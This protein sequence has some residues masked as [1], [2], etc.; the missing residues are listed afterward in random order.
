[1]FISEN[2]SNVLAAEESSY[3]DT[4]TGVTTEIFCL[5]I[6]ALVCWILIFVVEYIYGKKSTVSK[7]KSSS[8]TQESQQLIEEDVRMEQHRVN[9][10]SKE[11]IQK[12]GL[13]LQNV[14]KNYGDLKAVDNLSIGI[15]S[16]EC[17][18]LLGI[19]GAGKTTTFK[20]MT[21]DESIGSGDIWV[22]GINLKTDLKKAQQI[23]GYC[24]Q[25][26]ALMDNLTGWETLRMYC[27]L[28]GITGTD[29]KAISMGFAEDLDLKPHMNKL[30]KNYSG[31]NKRKLSTAIALLSR[32]NVIY[33]DE[34]TT[35]MD[36]ATRHKFWQVV[37]AARDSGKCVVLTSHSMEECEAL[38]TRLAIM[39]NGQFQ[40][41]GS[42]QHLK[43]KFTNGFTLVVK[44]K[45]Y[46]DDKMRLLD[47]VNNVK[48]FI[49]DTFQNST[50][51]EEH[52]ELL[53][54]HVHDRVMNWSYLFGT[55]QRAKQDLNIEDYSISQFN[56]EQVSK[57]QN[58]KKLRII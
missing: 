38:C 3:F 56:L 5:L 19:N 48:K 18:G 11:T 25:F 45:R 16:G 46:G 9:N 28:K 31:G 8:H 24:P 37:L 41:L 39:V 47:D 20:M 1:M 52:S 21:G 55:M 57:S 33:L 54:Y 34:P 42:I 43:N 53:T 27:Y 49:S 51:R 6:T 17:F 30:V 4:E 32:P 7:I 44:V 22:Q 58:L 29:V 12:H 23:I 14:S 40:C 13:V 26:D 36:P 50:L 10:F 15:Q 2:F 35:G